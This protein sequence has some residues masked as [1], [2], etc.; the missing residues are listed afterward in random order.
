MAF[1]VASLSPKSFI[2]PDLVSHCD[3]KL[4]ISRHRK[5]VTVETKKWLFQGDSLDA[6]KRK[7]FHGLNAGLLTAM[8]YPNAA[9][10]QLRVCNDFL[11]FL[12]HL[13]NLSDDMDN[14]GTH[15]IAD[16]VLN[17]LYFPY[18]YP[19]TARIG[20]MTKHLYKRVIPTSSPGTQ[21]RFIETM[22][23]FFQ[24]VTQQA[25]DRANGVI[26][27]L[28]S[29]IA[30]RRDTS[31]CK[32]CWALIEYAN[33]L[34][35]PD[36][37]MD[38]PTILALG[39]AANDLV[40][41]SNDIFS[42]NVEQSKGDTH[43]MIPVVMYQKDLSLQ[44]AVDFVGQMCKSSIDRF[45]AER[46]NLPSWGPHI[47]RQVNVYVQGLADWIV[48][49]LHWSFESTRYFGSNGR[50]IKS[51]RVVELLPLR[52]EARARAATVT[53]RPTLSPI[54]VPPRAPSPATPTESEPVTP[55]SS[56]HSIP[57]PKS[58][59]SEESI[60]HSPWSVQRSQDVIVSPIPNSPKPTLGR[61][62][63]E[64]L[65]VSETQEQTPESGVLVQYPEILSPAMANPLVNQ[66]I[67][68]NEPLGL[69]SLTIWLFYTLIYAPTMTLLRVFLN[70][71]VHPHPLCHYG[72]L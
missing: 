2:L 55:S 1:A 32:P 53:L 58:A 33:N 46:D 4:R 16:V 50:K 35:I 71:D 18:S 3:F 20:R 61:I 27:D 51:T 24:S 44:E 17:S 40:T 64:S 23:F 49:S 30:L 34:K 63:T 26:P 56:V 36:E 10:P 25:L 6:N 21:Q 43:N 7:A 72:Y 8:T 42:Y 41:W 52:Q 69:Y 28:D 13:D 66:R 12:F 37:V 14:R 19:S 57:V 38:H 48:G 29:Y 9:C 65:F 31:G 59:N 15:N 62:Q 68:R 39:E 11:T 5:Q 54:T 22:D 47:D 60:P 67:V 70:Q 45:K